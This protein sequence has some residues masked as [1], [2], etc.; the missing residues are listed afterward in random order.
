MV[1][2]LVQFTVTAGSEQQAHTFIQKMTEHTRREPGCRMYIGHQ[3][4][5]SSRRF[6]LYEQ[7]DNKEALDA[8]RAAPYFRDYITNGLGKL[9]ESVT[10]ELFQ[11]IQ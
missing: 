10:R 9:M 8:H 3:S 6:I 1:V 4:A 5:E 7:Y 11:P 2:L